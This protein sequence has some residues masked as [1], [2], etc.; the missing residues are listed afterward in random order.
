MVLRL[1]AEIVAPSLSLCQVKILDVR[2]EALESASRLTIGERVKSL[3]KARTYSLQTLA[4]LTDMSEATLSRIENE[5]TLVSAHNLYILS[6]VLDVDITAFFEPGSQ[7]MRTGVRSVSRHGESVTLATDRFTA[8]VLCTDLANKKM[9]PFIN[10]VSATTLEEAGG[11]NA[12]SGEEYLYVLD[13]EMVL[14]SEHYAPLRL[15]TGDST[16]FDGAMSHAYVNDNSEDKPARILVVTTADML[17]NE[18]S[19]NQ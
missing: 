6:R 15:Q 9:H 11:L 5:Q 4:K 7:P 1:R 19:A 13:G 8:E 3:R 12:H 17:R 2:N 18:K 10:L 14:H 16:Y